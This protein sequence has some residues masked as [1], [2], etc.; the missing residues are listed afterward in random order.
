MTNNNITPFQ[1]IFD[2]F[3]SKITDD[4]YLELTEE[5]TKRDM[6]GILV[7]SISGFEFPRF[8]LFNY[9]VSNRGEQGRYNVLLSHEE[10]D[11][12]SDLMVLEWT[13]RQIASV[14]NTRMKYSGSDF[15]FTSQANHLDK[16]IRLKREMENGSKHKQRLYKRR[17]VDN[18]SG[19]VTTNWSGM[20]GGVISGTR[21][22]I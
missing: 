4:L 13:K 16:L 8:P 20:A 3:L 14:E 7:N 11:I 19:A 18:S 10:V 22:E 12:I 5:D 1:Y 6:E 17:K 2:R 9:S 15:K 21:N